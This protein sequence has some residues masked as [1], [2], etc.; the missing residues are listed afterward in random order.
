MLLLPAGGS[1]AGI[2][3]QE[4]NHDGIA[5]RRNGIEADIAA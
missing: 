3:Q 5:P 4:I 1:H 2:A